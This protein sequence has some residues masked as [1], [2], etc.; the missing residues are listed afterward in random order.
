M[1]MKPTGAAIASTSEFQPP[2]FLT[3]TLFV[4]AGLLT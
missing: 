2:T 3:P 4:V 1:I